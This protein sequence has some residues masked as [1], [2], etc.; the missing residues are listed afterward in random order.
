MSAHKDIRWPERIQVRTEAGLGQSAALR[1][2]PGPAELW[3]E[4]GGSVRGV[5]GAQIQEP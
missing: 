3:G 1:Q 4:L 5:G 2:M